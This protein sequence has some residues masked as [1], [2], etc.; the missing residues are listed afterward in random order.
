MDTA[1]SAAP[2]A[3]TYE[4]LMLTNL[5]GVLRARV[6]APLETPP[7]VATASVYKL[8]APLR[9]KAADSPSAGK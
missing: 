4:Y 2:E 3:R 6:A 9:R 8:P 7:A 1:S 5:L